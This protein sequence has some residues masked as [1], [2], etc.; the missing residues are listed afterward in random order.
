MRLG[1]R[2]QFLFEYFVYFF[3]EHLASELYRWV[4]LLFDEPVKEASRQVIHSAGLDFG[5]AH[6]AAAHFTAETAPTVT[7]NNN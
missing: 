1:S 5:I 6:S 7:A 3:L 2:S 4:S